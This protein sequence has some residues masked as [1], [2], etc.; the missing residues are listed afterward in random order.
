MTATNDRF[1]AMMTA[2]AEVDL[3]LSA[4]QP[5]SELV[6]QD[7]T[8]LQAR[9]PAIDYHNHLD[10]ADADFVLRV[11]DECGIDRMVN[12]TMQ[13][14]ESALETMRRFREASPRRFATMAWMD[15]SGLERDDFAQL[16]VDRLERMVERGACGIKFWKDLGLSVRDRRGD[17]LRVDDERLA[18]IFEKAAELGVPVMFHTADPSA[19]FRPIDASNERYEE[20]A[21][22]PDWSFHGAQYGK[23]ELLA[24]R[25]R[26]LKRHPGTTFVCAHMAESGENLSYVSRLLEENRNVLVDISARTPELGRQP[27]SARRFFLHFA[28]RILFGTD[29]PPESPMYRLYFRFL[30][31]EDEYFEYP[32]H[33]SR[34]GRWNICGLN[35][36]DDVLERVYRTNALKLLPH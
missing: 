31:S 32:S 8:P 20:L 24:Q 23:E 4:F 14:G 16:S 9:F 7:S 12:I 25:D 27:Y 33:A 26:V 21:A 19:F 30:E 35:L 18:P 34:Q 22:H 29:L 1:L 28:D 11:M 17:L 5:H 15:W 36:P 2:K 10:G 6:T 3:R 13:V